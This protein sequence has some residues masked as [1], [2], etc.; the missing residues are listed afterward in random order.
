MVVA[1]LRVGFPWCLRLLQ[2]FG[3]DIQQLLPV[4]PFAFVAIA[5]T[6]PVYLHGN[7]AQ[8]GH[9]GR[10]INKSQT[11]G[12]KHGPSHSKESS[13]LTLTVLCVSYNLTVLPSL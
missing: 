13:L 7:L 9:F 6:G 3:V 11:C 4:L 2:D 10:K 8:C 1:Q 12:N 5:Y